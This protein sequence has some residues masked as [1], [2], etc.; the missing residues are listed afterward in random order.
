M[1]TE[2][3]RRVGERVV[4]S[5][6]HAAHVMAIDSTWRRGCNLLDVSE[7]GAKMTVEGSV[8][9]LP[10]K[11]FLLLCFRQRVSPF[12]A[13]N[14]LGSMAIKL[15]SISSRTVRAKRQKSALISRQPQSSVSWLAAFLPPRIDRP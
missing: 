15:E 8:T 6:G 4:F 12:V 11:E 1:A 13:A 14:W 3:Q 2:R 9:G 5:K 7:T 10:L